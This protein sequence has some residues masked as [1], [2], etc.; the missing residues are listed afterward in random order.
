MIKGWKQ[1]KQGQKKR[2]R[3]IK[4]YIRFLIVCFP[5]S[6]TKLNKLLGHPCS[7]QTKNNNTANKTT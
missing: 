3:E 5:Y 2:E 1:E 7:C 6:D 4:S